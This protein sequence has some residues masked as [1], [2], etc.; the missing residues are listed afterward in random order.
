MPTCSSSK[1]KSEVVVPGSRIAEGQ[2]YLGWC[3]QTEREKGLNKKTQ[4][5]WRR[6]SEMEEEFFEYKMTLLLA[7]SDSDIINQSL[8]DKM[9]NLLMGFRRSLLVLSREVTEGEEKGKLVVVVGAGVIF[10]G[11]LGARLHRETVKLIRSTI[12]LWLAKFVAGC[13]SEGVLAVC[14]LWREAEKAAGKRARDLYEEQFA[15]REDLLFINIE[16][17]Q[18]PTEAL[19]CFSATINGG[20]FGQAKLWLRTRKRSH[21]GL[22]KERARNT[23]RKEDGDKLISIVAGIKYTCL[24]ENN[25]IVSLLSVYDQIKWLEDKE[26]VMARAWASIEV[27]P[28]ISFDDEGHGIY[29]QVGFFG[30]AGWNCLVFGP[31]FF[32]KEM[33]ELLES[34]RTIVTGKNIHDDLSWIL[35][36][37][38][39]W[40][41]VDLGVWTR[42]LK[43]HGHEEN[44]LK[45]MFEET[46]GFKKIKI[47]K[48]HPENRE[49]FGYIRSGNWAREKLDSRQLTYMAADVTLP[50]TVVFNILITLIMELGV[51]TLDKHFQ[52][53]E[54][55][56]APYVT[57]VIDRRFNEKLQ[58]PS[59]SIPI[60]SRS[61]SENVA[62][63]A[64]SEEIYYEDEVKDELAEER[65]ERYEKEIIRLGQEKLVKGMSGGGPVWSKPPE[66][67]GKRGR[68]LAE[69]QEVEELV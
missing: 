54:A 3:K 62:A 47:D 64:L 9:Q 5:V 6:F 31:A 15:R 24:L 55:F 14:T 25:M 13:K 51:A 18:I 66:T 50:G 67:R 1:S 69:K 43:F 38:A 56:V 12:L 20:E 28:F 45:K 21:A 7:S 42:D 19:E 32:P 40:R 30:A 52:S 26:K 17:A 37:Q 59:H 16:G 35:G 22:Q 65:R 33:M 58:H 29:F 11:Q 41:A 27:W 4:N 63:L 57:R 53:L 61:L 23:K 68:D 39:G 44:G 49:K 8:S 48:N 60:D 36:S 46:L 2:Q 34:P 10:A